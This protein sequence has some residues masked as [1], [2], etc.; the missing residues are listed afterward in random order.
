MQINNIVL[1]AYAWEGAPVWACRFSGPVSLA[2]DY[3]SREVGE[4]HLRTS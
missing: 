1:L 3:D 2:S 4:H